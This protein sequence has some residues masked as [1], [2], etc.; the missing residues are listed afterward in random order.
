[1][2]DKNLDYMG[3]SKSRIGEK[4]S[5]N[6]PPSKRFKRVKILFEDSISFYVESLIDKDGK[7]FGK[8]YSVKKHC[9]WLIPLMT[10]DAEKAPNPC[11]ICPLFKAVEEM[12][13][14]DSK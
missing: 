1:M 5:K 6:Q 7:G 12:K 3:Y 8:R 2:L 9:F 11:K 10:L 13:K 14:R 4:L